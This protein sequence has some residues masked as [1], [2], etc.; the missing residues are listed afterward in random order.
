MRGPIWHI[1]WRIRANIFSPCRLKHL[2]RGFL[3]IFQHCYFVLTVRHV[4][5]QHRDPIDILHSTVD[6]HEVTPARQDLSKAS[7]V[8]SDSRLTQSLFVC[9]SVSRGMP[10][11][12]HRGAPFISITAEEI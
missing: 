10:V 4:N 7:D 12:I 5:L 3:D 9:F 1:W 6:F 2:D 11:E 8:E